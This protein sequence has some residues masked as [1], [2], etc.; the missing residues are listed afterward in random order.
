MNGTDLRDLMAEADRIAA[1]EYPLADIGRDFAEQLFPLGEL[2]DEPA[3][4]VEDAAQ[5]HAE[6]LGP[7]WRNDVP[8]AAP[9]GGRRA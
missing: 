5:D 8:V 7:G 2:D 6:L 9:S 4:V 1:S 3:P